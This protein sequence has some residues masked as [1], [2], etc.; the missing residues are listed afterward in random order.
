[1]TNQTPAEK[2]TEARDEFLFQRIRMTR[3]AYQHATTDELV[4]LTKHLTRW[5]Q[6][7]EKAHGVV[8]A[9]KGATRE[10]GGE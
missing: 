1:M 3:L 4:R 5:N 2:A 8:P 10:D 6:D 9:W 7:I